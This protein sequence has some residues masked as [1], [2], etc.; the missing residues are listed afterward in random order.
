MN[1]LTIEYVKSLILDTP[2]YEYAS[3]KGV[4]TKFNIELG[5]SYFYVT[6]NNGENV[7]YQGN[8][9]EKATKAYNDTIRKYA[10]DKSFLSGQFIKDKIIYSG[11]GLGITLLNHKT[12]L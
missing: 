1:R 9:V 11:D 6:S 8:D 7:D 3:I 4:G 2:Y 10:I 12:L 5:D